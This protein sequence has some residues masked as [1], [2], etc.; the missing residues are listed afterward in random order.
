MKNISNDTVRLEKVQAGCGCTTPQWKPGPYQP[1]ETF[2]AVIGFNGFGIT[3]DG[4]FNKIVTV[5]LSNGMSQVIRFHGQTYKTPDNPAPGNS[6]AEKIK[7]A[8]Q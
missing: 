2:K 6:A 3:A 5:Y 4:S 7:P 8:N 1:G